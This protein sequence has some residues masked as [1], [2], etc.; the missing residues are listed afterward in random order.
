MGKQRFIPKPPRGRISQ[1]LPLVAPP[2]PPAVISRTRRTYPLR[3]RGFIVGVLPAVQSPPFSWSSRRPK[4]A[5]RRAGT[6]INPVFGGRG[7]LGPGFHQ[8]LTRSVRVAPKPRGRIV[9][10]PPVRPVFNT[11]A[12]IPALIR[13]GKLPVL[14]QWHSHIY[15]VT[16]TGAAKV[17]PPPLPVFIHQRVRYS[18]PKRGHISLPSP[19]TPGQPGPL[20]PQFLRLYVFGWRAVRPKRGQVSQPPWP[21]VG[22]IP[23]PPTPLP[24]TPEEEYGS[25]SWARRQWRKRHRPTKGLDRSSVWRNR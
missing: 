6:V 21:G 24:T 1:V 4:L 15:I 23:P 10:P 3:R 22:P 16:P 7:V 5:T 9:P 14:K 17:L 13:R 8:F 19:K 25:M 12:Y 11:G 18:T 2:L 20:T